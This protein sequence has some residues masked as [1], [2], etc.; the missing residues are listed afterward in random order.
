MQ[1]FRY[2]PELQKVSATMENNNK[3]TPM[4]VSEFTD[5]M[6]GLGLAAALVIL[7]LQVF[8]PFIG[9]MLWAVILAATLY[10]M[11]QALAR[12]MGD[13]Q[14]RSATVIVLTG[15]LIMGVPLV[16]LGTSLANHLA[17]SYQSFQNN[18][19]QIT[20]P[21]ASVADWPVIGKTVFNAWSEMSTNL[22]EFIEKNKA[23]VQGLVK[24]G[25]SVSAGTIGSVFLFLGAL[26]IA[27]IMM[28]YGKSGSVAM[29]RIVSRFSG[30]ERGPAILT[31]STL[32]VR[33]VAAGVLGVAL[34]QALI[35]GVGFFF[36]GVPAAGVLAVV[37]LFLGILQL[38]AIIITIPVVA[39]IWGTGDGSTVMNS[40]WSVYLIVGGFSD[41]ILKPMLLGRGV[42]AP[43]PVI[44]I[45]ALGG[46]VSAGIVGLFVGA[47][48][49]AVGY[50]LLM[51]WVARS[52]ETE[53]VES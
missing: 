9:V 33:S 46:M 31:L 20:Q 50:R 15:L 3:N 29:E 16:L 6:I 53:V 8:A 34:I 36:A 27:G 26:I 52:E 40:I 48:L 41:G 28:A 25:I 5:T 51:E 42:D 39:W 21:K 13:R 37:I 12:R 35:L 17:D 14:G 10:P 4:T 38:P 45:G 49:L 32:T 11:H 44:L 2:S 1:N 30:Q 24:R 22:P 18:T 43:M 7:C 19:I 23:G 47:V